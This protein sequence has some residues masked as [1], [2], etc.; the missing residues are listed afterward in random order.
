MS[1][2]PPLDVWVVTDGR[3]GIEAQ[4]LGLAEAVAA[5][6]PA[7]ITVKRVAWRRW[8]RRL[9][10]RLVPWPWLVLDRRADPLRPPWPDLWIA[11]GRAAIPAS[12][13]VRRWSRGRTFTVMV[14]DPLRPARLFDMVVPPTHDEL[15]G[16]GVF[17]ILGAPH[18][19]SAARKE[20]AYAEFR[21]RLES[22]PRPRTLVLVG[23]RS[24]A[25]D[26]SPARAQRLADQIERAVGDSGGALLMTF[27]R[28]TPAAA[29]AI[30][31][32]RLERLPGWIWEGEGAN[33]LAAFLHA[34]DHVIVT[35]DSIN[36]AAEAASTG[37]P[38]H[39]AEMDGSQA[40]KN[41]FHAALRAHGAARPFTGVLDS[42]TYP[43]LRET[44]RAAARVSGNHD[45]WVAAPLQGLR[46][47][48]LEDEAL[49]A[50]LLEDMLGD[51]GCEIA[52][53]ASRVAQAVAF[54]ADPAN[55]VDVAV[56]DVN[57]AGETSGPAAQALADRGVPLVFATGYGESGLPD[58]FRGRPT[59]Q[60]PFGMADVERRLREATG[61]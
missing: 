14:Q 46:V 49:V 53:T 34:A 31:R 24:K 21:G 59:L 47:L 1:G 58:A 26:L 42:W 4:A 36:M 5:R 8:L 3:A 6:A 37:A 48:I 41:R 22:L 13:A 38:V 23:G 50:M 12:I 52:L 30:L 32:A 20:A 57:V 54:T 39:I 11:A 16:P 25:F 29:A 28:R 35:E 43:P 45:A 33:P 60:K 7:R 18:R 17:P 27:S 9:P 55:S 10:T 40:R 44:E 61:R 51:L 15:S 2:A 19:M 56:L